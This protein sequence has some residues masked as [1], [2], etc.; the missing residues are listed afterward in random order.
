M[1]RPDRYLVCMDQ[2][3]INPRKEVNYF[4][5]REDSNQ[6]TGARAGEETGMQKRVLKLFSLVFYVY[7][8]NYCV[9]PTIYLFPQKH[10]L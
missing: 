6:E 5:F 2:P 1:L 3:Y 10:Q 4:S 9:D 7:I 8:S